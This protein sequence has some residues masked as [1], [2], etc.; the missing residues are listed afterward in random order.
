MTL[1][2]QCRAMLRHRHGVHSPRSLRWVCSGSTPT[3][4]SLPHEDISLFLSE[5]DIL[6]RLANPA[7]QKLREPPVGPGGQCD[8][9]PTLQHIP[10]FVLPGVVLHQLFRSATKNV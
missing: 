9:H 10:R 4:P 7:V 6:E 5:P 3:P 1:R 8:L 2:L